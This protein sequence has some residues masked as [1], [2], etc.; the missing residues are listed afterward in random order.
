MTS[1]LKN[2]QQFFVFEY[3][4]L[5]PIDVPSFKLI[6]SQIKELQG[7]VPNT[8]HPQAEN[9]QKS[10]GGIGLSLRLRLHGVIYRPDSFVLMLRYCVNLKVIRYESMNLNRIIA[11]KSH[12]VIVA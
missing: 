4:L 10:P 6:E 12:R 2:A 5:I 9:D 11:D 8:P 1:F 3:F 7:L